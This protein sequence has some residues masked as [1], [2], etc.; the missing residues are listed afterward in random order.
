MTDPVK[1]LVMWLRVQLDEDEQ[2][3]WEASMGPW[4]RDGAM[5]MGEEWVAATRNQDGYADADHI[6]EYDP[7]RALAEVEAKRRILDLWEATNT[8][9]EAASGT[10][11]AGAARVRLGAY[12]KAVQAIALPYVERPGYRAEW[13]PA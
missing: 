6:V 5:V 12:D 4:R 8:A 9:L 1:G 10:I 3:A 13:C 7:V 2:R 11:L